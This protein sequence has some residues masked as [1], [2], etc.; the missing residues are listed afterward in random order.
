[1]REAE[2]PV[3][4]QPRAEELRGRPHGGCGSSQGAEGQR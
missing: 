3:F 1:M 2:V 4:A